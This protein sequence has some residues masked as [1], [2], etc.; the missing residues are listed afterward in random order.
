MAAYGRFQGMLKS[1]FLSGKRDLQ[2]STGTSF[3]TCVPSSWPYSGS[4]H[5]VMFKV[6]DSNARDQEAGKVLYSSTRAEI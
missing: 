3:L 5:T 1:A 6:V 4:V 2:R